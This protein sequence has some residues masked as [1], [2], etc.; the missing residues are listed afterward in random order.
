MAS[1]IKKNSQGWFLLRD[2]TTQSRFSIW[3]TENYKKP[4][5]RR[6]KRAACFGRRQ[7]RRLVVFHLAVETRN[8]KPHGNRFLLRAGPTF[9]PELK[10]DFGWCWPLIKNTRA[11][12]K[13]IVFLILD[14]IN[15]SLCRQLLGVRVGIYGH[16]RFDYCRSLR[17]QLQGPLS[18]L[19]GPSAL[20]YRGS[21]I[22]KGYPICRILY[23]RA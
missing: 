20:I 22:I 23:M 11:F 13:N 5:G 17:Q 19:W 12:N 9:G 15:W 3:G 10:T 7:R 18:M 6:A 4:K 1:K 21:S 8:K 16:L 2:S 14:T